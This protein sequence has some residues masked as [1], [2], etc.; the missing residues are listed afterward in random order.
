MLA[1]NKVLVLFYCFLPRRFRRDFNIVLKMESSFRNVIK[2][3]RGHA[4]THFMFSGTV[5]D[6]N[7]HK[8]RE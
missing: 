5:K 1:E 8:S 6:K 7:G 4:V 3:N 2:E